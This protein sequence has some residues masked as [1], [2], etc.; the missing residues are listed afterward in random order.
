L[1]KDA[2]IFTVTENR[3]VS[4][5]RQK[6][7][8]GVHKTLFGDFHYYLADSFNEMTVP[9]TRENRYDELAFLRR[10]RYFNRSTPAIR[11][12]FGFMQGWIFMPIQVSGIKN[13]QALY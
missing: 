2:Y 3:I 5:Y 9:V 13:P 4:R 10:T 7:Y 1:K 8:Q 11:T 6:I 12:A